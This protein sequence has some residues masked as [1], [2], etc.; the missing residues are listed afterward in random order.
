[1]QGLPRLL[2]GMES[3]G[4]LNDRI[5]AKMDAKISTDLGNKMHLNTRILSRPFCKAH[6]R[7]MINWIFEVPHEFRDEARESLLEGAGGVAQG[8]LKPQ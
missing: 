3:E 8:K 6:T 1:M 2:T 5:C 7:M 4:R